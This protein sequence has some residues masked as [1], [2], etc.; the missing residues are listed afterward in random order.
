MIVYR[1]FISSLYELITD[2]KLIKRDHEILIKHLF[3]QTLLSLYLKHINRFPIDVKKY[4]GIISKGKKEILDIHL[5]SMQ[6]AFFKKRRKRP[7]CFRAGSL[8]TRK[9]KFF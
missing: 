2:C 8:K 5:I 6:Q 1:F 7:L 4:L 9:G 3:K